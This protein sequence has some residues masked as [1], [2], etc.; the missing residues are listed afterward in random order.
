MIDYLRQSDEE[1]DEDEDDDDD[2]HNLT[3]GVW[4][5][6]FTD[7]RTDRN[8]G[9]LLGPG[10]LRQRGVK[11]RKDERLRSWVQSSI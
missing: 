7:S 9:W 5:G 1:R 8:I 10:T 11:A 4:Q 3:G 6:W 2:D